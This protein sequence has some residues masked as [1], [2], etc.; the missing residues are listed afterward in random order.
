MSAPTHDGAFFAV[1]LDLGAGV[2]AGEHLVAH[3]DS[4]LDFLAVHDTAGANGHDLCHL[5]L[6]F[7]AAGRDEAAL[8]GLLDLNSLDNN[9]VCK[10][11][12]LHR[13]CPPIINIKD[14]LFYV[15]GAAP[16]RLFSTL[17]PLSAKCIVLILESKI[18][19]FCK[20]LC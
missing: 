17:F 14:K 9:T 5:G 12:D 4:H 2:L 15:P 3:L 1:H 6:L 8:G 11:N 16:F 19:G 20:F 18:K 13:S 10:R 7:G